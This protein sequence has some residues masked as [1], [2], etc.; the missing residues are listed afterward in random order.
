MKLKTGLVSVI[1]MLAPVS[2][3][4]AT[5]DVEVGGEYHFNLVNTD[6]GLNPDAAQTKETDFGVKA[7]KIALRGKLTDQIT[8]NVLFQADKSPGLERYWVTNKVTDELDVSIGVQKIRA[9]GWHR[10]LTSSLSPVRGAYLE[11][12]PYKD[13]MA[14]DFAYKLGSNALALSLAKDYFDTQATCL[15]TGVG[16][17]SWNGRDV[18][19]QPAVLLEWAGTYGSIQPL[20]QYSTYDRAKSSIVSAGVRFKSEVVDAYVDYTLDTRKTKKLNAATG[21]FEGQD[22]KINGLAVYGEYKAGALSPFIQYTTLNVDDYTTGGAPEPDTN[23]D[24][25]LN[26]NEQTAVIGTYF[27]SWGGLYRPYVALAQFTGKFMKDP[28]TAEK[29]DRSKTDLM[30]GLTGKF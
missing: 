11:Y 3:L 7:A 2:L 10:R 5:V 1:S 18:Q 14:I 28:A 26:D 24:G 23:K 16:C 20:V 21:Q 12:N 15:P 22:K 27:E 30:A 9:Y 8:W 29:E 4:A 17:E 25:S 6:D 19:K 13:V